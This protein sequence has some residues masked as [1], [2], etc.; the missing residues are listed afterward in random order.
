M[1]IGK[2]VAEAVDKMQA[3]DPD[4]ALFAICAAVEATAVKG[5]AVLGFGEGLVLHDGLRGS[6]M[7]ASKQAALGG[8]MAQKRPGLPVVDQRRHLLTSRS[9][10]ELSRNRRRSLAGG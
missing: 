3:H 4:G 5:K 8:I 10:I 9:K 2:Q 6:T 7:S 1:G